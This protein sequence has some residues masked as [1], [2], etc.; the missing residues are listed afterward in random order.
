M[1]QSLSAQSCSAWQDVVSGYEPTRLA[2]D[3]TA[4]AKQRSSSARTNSQNPRNQRQEAMSKP[5]RIQ[6]RRTK[7]WKMPENCV[8]VTRPGKF[9]NPYWHIAKFH[10]PEKAVEAFRMTATGVW[11]PTIMNQYPISYYDDHCEWLKSIVMHP[12]DFI[13]CELCGKDLACWCALCENHKDGLPLGE[14]CSDCAP[15][16]ADVLLELANQ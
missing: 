1:P 11:N 2:I 15:C 12:L 6:R 9:G 3:I 5:K 16:H 4:S 8:C 14:K 13:T 10:G 7:G